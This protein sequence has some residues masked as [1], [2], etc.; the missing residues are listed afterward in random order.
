MADFLT[1]NNLCKEYE[2]RR[3]LHKVSLSLQ[4]GDFLSL[5]GPNGAGKSTLLRIIA[6]L[7][8]PSSGQVEIKGFD[9]QEEPEAFKRQLGVISHQSLLYGHMT[10]RE[11]LLFYGALYKVEDPQQRADELLRVVELYP[12]RHSRVSRFSRG[13]CQRLSIARALVNDPSLLLLDEPFS[14]LD[15]YAAAILTRQLDE[16][17][18]RA[19]TVIM[20]THSL[21]RGLAAAGKVGI[22]AG[23]RLLYL[24]D[25]DTIDPAAFEGLYLEHVHGARAA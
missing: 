25:R 20:V 2:G 5:F 9:L 12:R 19:R 17:R 8:S 13:M 16:L 3:A 18:T 24:E 10:A 6:T 21:D 1:V 4:Q 22:L 14:G 15:Q 7:I 23:G 11:N